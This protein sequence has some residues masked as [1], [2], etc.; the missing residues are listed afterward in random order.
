MF[1]S[2]IV[3]LAAVVITSPIGAQGA[4]DH[5]PSDVTFNLRRS[6]LEEL[7][8]TG[9]TGHSVG[10]RW[11]E[12]LRM[13]QHSAVHQLASDCEIHVGAKVPNNR[14]IAAPPGIVVEPPNVCKSR[15][16]QTR[17]T[18]SIST[19]WTSYFD[20]KVTG[21]TCDVVGFP[22][23]F[24]EHAAG[25]GTSGS[26][27]DHVVEIHPALSM[28]CNG[29]MVNYL[30][31]LKV[32]PGMRAISDVSASACLAERT[33][34]VRQKQTGSVPIYEFLEEGAKGSGGRCGNFIVVEANIG[35]EYLRELSNGGDHVA[36]ARV[37]IGEDGPYPL[38][39]YTYKGTPEDGAIATLL[40]STDEYAGINLS[41]HGVLT[42]DYFSIVQ[43]VQ[44]SSFN[45]LPP[46]ALRDYREVKSPLALVVFGE[47]PKP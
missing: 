15:V 24:S 46:A 18:G 9:S 42:Y 5:V 27:P 21:Q 13:D 41:L 16:P 35:K 3:A 25:G 31:L 2:T 32:Y 38:K 29:E 43:A 47:E 28:S 40:A 37:W 23:I 22:R 11:K 30:P 36:L 12:T 20:D 19:A 1:R 33:L 26:N 34:S 14:V 4:G 6:F 17:Q 44:D 10:A 8:T 39:I 45:W 7:M